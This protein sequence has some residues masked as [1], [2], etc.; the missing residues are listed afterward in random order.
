MFKLNSQISAVIFSALNNPIDRKKWL[1]QEISYLGLK[2]DGLDDILLEAIMPLVSLY[3]NGPSSE[4]EISKHTEINMNMLVDY[5]ES[6]KEYNLIDECSSTGKYQLTN[7]GSQACEDIFK[8]VVKRKRL[9]LIGD[10][11]HIDRIY[12]QLDKL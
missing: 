4:E 11:E 5:L 3:T 7:K 10:L 1:G 9:D 12:G 6:L 2:Y 8:N